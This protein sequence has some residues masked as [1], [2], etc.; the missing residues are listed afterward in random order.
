MLSIIFESLTRSSTIVQPFGK[1]VLK[2]CEMFVY[3]N[4]SDSKQ[5]DE[6]WRAKTNFNYLSSPTISTGYSG[7]KAKWVSF[8]L[9]LL[10]TVNRRKIAIILFTA[11]ENRWSVG[12]L[13][14]T[15]DRVI[16]VL[17][18]ARSLCCVPIPP[19]RGQRT[20]KPGKKKA[21]GGVGVGVVNC[22]EFSSHPRGVDK[23]V[24]GPLKAFK[25]HLSPLTWVQDRS[26]PCFLVCP[27]NKSEC[28]SSPPGIKPTWLFAQ[29]FIL[30]HV[31]IVHID[32]KQ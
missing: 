21:G 12:W 23:L 19:C 11:W 25:L 24:H 4:F 18:L 32:L 13:G 27:H 2:P 1:E 29:R 7:L 5:V 31:Q 9:F 16:W 14:L 15:P 28:R 8:V 30:V 17:A 3:S 20:K 6:S 22:D 10:A 26:Q